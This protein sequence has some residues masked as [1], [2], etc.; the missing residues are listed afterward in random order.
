M[1]MRYYRIMNPTGMPSQAQPDCAD[2]EPA[3][4]AQSWGG[5]SMDPNLPSGKR[6]HNYGK[7][8]F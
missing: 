4:T 3:E 5:V 8:P 6:L 7:S 1:D 2:P